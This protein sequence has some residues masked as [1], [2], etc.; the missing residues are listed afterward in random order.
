MRFLY[1]FQPF[2]VD[3]SHVYLAYTEESMRQSLM[4]LERP[5]TSKSGKARP[6]TGRRSDHISYLMLFLENKIHCKSRL[7]FTVKKRAAATRLKALL[8]DHGGVFSKLGLYR[9]A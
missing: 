5:R 6:K 8:L 2:E 3:L 9:K 4:R 7:A 1:A